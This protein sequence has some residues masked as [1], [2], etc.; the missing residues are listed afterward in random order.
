MIYLL[1]ADT[2]ITSARVYYPR[3]RWLPFWEWL[4]FQGSSG[5]VK[6]PIEQYEEVTS[7][8][9]TD[10]LVAWLKES[11]IKNSLALDE[12]ADPKAVRQVILQGYAPD[13]TDVELEKIGRDPFLIAYAL[14]DPQ[15]RCV[16]SFENSAPSKT[17]ANRKVPD[18]CAF[19]GI[20][21][22]KIFDVINDLDFTTDW[23][24]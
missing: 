10:D 5:K 3:K 11:E 1:D 21:C 14:V 4:A 9:K 18:V 22:T 16:V 15:N 8:Q 12:S 2:L 24:R 13:L 20:K 7:G 6:I 23:K 17:R 19:L